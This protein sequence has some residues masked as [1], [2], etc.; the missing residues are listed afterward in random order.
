MSVDEAR[1]NGLAF[2]INYGGIL[3]GDCSNFSIGT[4]C[5]N[6]VA[7]NG[8]SLGLREVV[9]DCEHIGIGENG[10]DLGR[11]GLRLDVFRHKRGETGGSS[12]G[13]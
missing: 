4:H 12:P 8:D 13:L 11:C 2:K 1:Q 10:C 3:S 7:T 5:Q 6:S 9:I